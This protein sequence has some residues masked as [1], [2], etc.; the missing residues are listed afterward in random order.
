MATGT[1]QAKKNRFQWTIAWKIGGLSMVLMMFILALLIYSIICLRGLQTELKELAGLEV[2]LMGL[3][4]KIEIQHLEQQV[5]LD[6]LLRLHRRPE[7]VKNQH[8][9]YKQLLR[10]HSEALDLHLERGILLSK[11]GFQTEYRPMFESI[12][13]SLLGVQLHE[14]RL[15]T[16]WKDIIDKMDSG[17]NPD[18][19]VIEGA[20]SQEEEFDEKIL[21]LIQKVELFTERELSALEKHNKIL[22]MVNSALGISGVIIGTILS[23]IIIVG[24]RSNLFRLTQRISEVTQ[25]IKE[26]G[27]IPTAPIGVKSSDEI[28]EMAGKLSV[29]LSSVSADFQKRDELSRHL[30]EVA[31]SDKLTG[32]F[33]RLKWEE[34]QM[35]E[36]ERVRRNQG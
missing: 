32:A 21:N 6:Q 23:L 4:N 29:M 9:K 2:P 7:L 30:K 27:V 14:V 15:Y 3:V 12:H 25:S 33:N 18:G 22:F 26:S 8:L 35:L 34:N 20:L 10:A 16:I 13:T 24:I 36:I 28:G 11:V 31:T 17:I 19:Q 5:I 1:A